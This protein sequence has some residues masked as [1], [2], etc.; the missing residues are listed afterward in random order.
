M[1][2]T[3]TSKPHILHIH[4]A[5]HCRPEFWKKL[6][7]SNYFHTA[8]CN[9]IK[10]DFINGCL[11]FT[12]LQHW[13]TRCF[14]IPTAFPDCVTEKKENSAGFSLYGKVKQKSCCIFRFCFFLEWQLLT[15][16]EFH[17]MQLF[18]Q[19]INMHNQYNVKSLAIYVIL[20]LHCNS[21]QLKVET[22]FL[23]C[24]ICFQI[25]A[26]YFPLW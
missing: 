9:D 13:R 11:F 19:N 18:F 5:F 8:F 2:N 24:A 26:I 1:V 20:M 25:I 6:Y 4:A 23:V 17:L 10:V 22:F 12:M 16:H 3:E 15:K 14:Y 7:S 21:S